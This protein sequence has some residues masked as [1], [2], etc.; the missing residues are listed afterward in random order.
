M[1]VG[2]LPFVVLLAAPAIVSI[3][4]AGPSGETR[5]PLRYDRDVRPI[6]ADRCFPCHGPD[7]NKRQAELR[8]D[9]LETA[10][11]TREHG[12]A[13]VPGKPAE[14]EL[15]HRITNEDV[16]ERM[17]PAT[18]SRKQLS[19]DERGTLRRWIEE[20]A[21]YEPHWSFVPPVRPPVPQGPE[22]RDAQSCRNAVDR[23]IRARLETEGVAPSPEAP[24]ATQLRRLFL[25]LTGLPPTPEEYEAFLAD[26]NPDRHERWVAKLLTEEPYRTR[27]AER[28]ATPWLDQSRYADTCG[29]HMDAGRQMWLW[30]DWVLAAYRDDMPFDRFVTE[31]IGRASCRER[32]LLGV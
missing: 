22:V 12:A 28:M 14:S 11:A 19:D 29:I 13:I 26:S 5:G 16:D 17:P 25:D 10:T 32:V 3:A 4:P 27:Y 18:S 21:R 20:G 24:P 1:G 31:Q 30:R 2:R 15:W 9:Q 8:L 23:F 7:A 6:L